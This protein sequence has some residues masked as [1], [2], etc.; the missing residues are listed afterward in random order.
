MQTTQQ[1]IKNKRE[2]IVSVFKTDIQEQELNRLMPVL[3]S[4]NKIIK[5]NTDLEDC[6]NILRIESYEIIVDEIINLLTK[7]G[8]QIEELGD[9]I[10]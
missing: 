1:R 5:W 8:I 6:D 2:I 4:F 7:V 10:K 3:N 9:E